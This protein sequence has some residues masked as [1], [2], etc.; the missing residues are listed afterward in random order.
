M[1]NRGPSYGLSR[2]VQ[3]KIE[4]K[5]DADLE[6]KLV[7]WIILQCAEDIEHPPPGRTHFQKWLMDGTE[8][9]AE[10]ERIFRGATS[11]GTECHRPADGQQQGCLPGR[12][13]GVRD[14]QAD[15]VRC[16]IVSAPW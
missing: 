2:E 13:D 8:S 7:D 1:A 10:S 9:P 14:A 16:C 5:Y 3:E 4:Q 11:P 12:H 6:N 15:H